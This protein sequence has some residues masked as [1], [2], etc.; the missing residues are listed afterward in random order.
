MAFWLAII[1]GP[2]LGFLGVQMA[3]LTRQLSWL[4][5]TISVFFFSNSSSEGIPS[6]LLSLISEDASPSA[7]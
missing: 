1:F 3:M 6:S 2:C 5:K 7:L 4:L